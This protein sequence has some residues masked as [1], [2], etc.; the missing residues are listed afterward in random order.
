MIWLCIGAGIYLLDFFVKNLAEKRL[1]GKGRQKVGETG[2]FLQLV[3][4]KGFALN[5][6]EKRPELVRCLQAVLMGLIGLYSVIKVFFR[7]GKNLTSLGFAMILGGGASNL[8]DR[9]KR[10]YVVD[11]LGLP[12]MKKIVFNLSDLFIFLG[13]F[14]VLLGELKEK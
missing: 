7:T 5:M 13:S 14:L 6:L 1:S 10:G 2:F 8:F 9:V 3:H 4:N 11:Y 12:K